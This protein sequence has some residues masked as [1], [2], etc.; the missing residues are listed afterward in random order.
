M[1]RRSLL[2]HT[3]ALGAGLAISAVHAQEERDVRKLKVAVVAW[4]A[5]WDMCRRFCRSPMWRSST[6]LRWIQSDSTGG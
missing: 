5:A 4:G 3:T 2:K 6:W 1:N